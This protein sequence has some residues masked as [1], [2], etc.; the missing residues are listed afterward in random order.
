MNSKNIV[1]GK[2]LFLD[3]MRKPVDCVMYTGNAIYAV[4]QWEVVKNFEEFKEAIDNSLSTGDLYQSIS[5]D[6]DLADEH[7]VPAKYWNNYDE[8]EKYQK[9]KETEYKEKTGYDCILYMI[10]QYEKY[11]VTMPQRLYCHSM[12]PVGK[13]K[14]VSEIKRIKR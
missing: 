6:H 8:S 4:T 7:Y 5:F 1:P 12:N 14:I 11:G 3:D 13:T 9:E 2:Q 10:E